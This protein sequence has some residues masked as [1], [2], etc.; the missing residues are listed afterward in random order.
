MLW[1]PILVWHKVVSPTTNVMK[2]KE[3]LLKQFFIKEF[4]LKELS[5]LFTMC[6]APPLFA[7]IYAIHVCS[8]ICVPFKF[9]KCGLKFCLCWNS[10]D[11]IHC[12]EKAMKMIQTQ[13]PCSWSML[14]LHDLNQYW[15]K[16]DT[17]HLHCVIFVYRWGAQ[18]S[19]GIT[20]W[21]EKHMQNMVF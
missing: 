15:H 14:P 10:V 3:F 8:I 20:F 11:H 12:T 17:L 7:E 2:I 6:N 18:M 21:W 13:Y 1:Y 16:Q 5:N 4:S 9:I 19:I